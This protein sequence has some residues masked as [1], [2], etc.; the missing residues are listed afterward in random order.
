MRAVR[1]RLAA[2][3]ATCVVPALCVSA[4]LLYEH[5]RLQRDLAYRDTVLMARNVAADIN[6]CA[7]PACIAQTT[8]SD[9]FPPDWFVT[10]FLPDGTIVARTPNPE[11]FVGRGVQP[12]LQEIAAANRSG[13]FNTV[14]LDGVDVVS[15]WTHIASGWGVAVSA[16][17]VELMAGL[18]R[19]LGWAAAG[20]LMALSLAIWLATRVARSVVSLAH[21]DN[22]TGACGRALFGELVDRQIALATRAQAPL[23]ML[24]IDLD[25]F[26]GVNDTHGHPTG[27]AVLRLAAERIENCIR[28]SDVLARVGGDEFAVMLADVS[29]EQA[30][31]I[32]AKLVAALSQPYPGVDVRVSASVGVAVFPLDWMSAT[33]LLKCADAALYEAKRQGKGRVVCG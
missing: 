1:K 3:I 5:Y 7:E 23:A 33:G 13:T 2:L 27:D 21:R 12:D 18:Y 26:K 14:T 22:L 15:S 9:L 16:P 6:R 17:R 8:H 31:V 30:E 19:G 24:A 20:V 10:I 28:A 11:R 4:A 32:G 29:I 25:G